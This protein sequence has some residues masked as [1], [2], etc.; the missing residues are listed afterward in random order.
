MIEFKY[1]KDRWGGFQRVSLDIWCQA[2]G[3]LLLVWGVS[4][5]SGAIF[6]KGVGFPVGNGRRVRFLLDDWAGVGPLTLLYPRVFRV[7]SNKEASIYEY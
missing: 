4:L 3:V 1:G 7:V 6:C 5:I 2:F